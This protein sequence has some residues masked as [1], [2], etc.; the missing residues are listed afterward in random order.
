MGKPAPNVLIAGSAQALSAMG[1]LF[2]LFG[3]PA[4]NFN[5]EGIKFFILLFLIYYA[6]HFPIM[7]LARLTNTLKVAPQSRSTIE[8]RTGQLFIVARFVR[9]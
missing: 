5:A 7:K 1:C 6:N 9:S 4:G 3:L 2:T 8:I